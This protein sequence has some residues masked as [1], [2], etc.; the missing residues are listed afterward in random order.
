MGSSF[1]GIVL[2]VKSN[3]LLWG[4]KSGNGFLPAST[5][6]W[7]TAT[8]ALNVFGPSYRFTTKTKRGPSADQVIL[9]GSGDPALSSG[10]LATLAKATATTPGRPTNSARSSRANF[11]A[12]LPS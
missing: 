2:D 10:Q 12:C 3:T 4:R 6:K 8:N 9:V 1:G 5:T 11:T 7:V